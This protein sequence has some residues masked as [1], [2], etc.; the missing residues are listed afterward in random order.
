MFTDAPKHGIP[1]L[2]FKTNGV[3]SRTIH[4]SY[5]QKDVQTTPQIIARPTVT[6][7]LAL[8]AQKGMQQHNKSYPLLQVGFLQILNLNVLNCHAEKTRTGGFFSLLCNTLYAPNNSKEVI[9]ADY[10]EYLTPLTCTSI[11]P[12]LSLQR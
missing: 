9:A 6:K 2:Y 5:L 1:F 8:Q 11:F 12:T 7:L 10:L 4:Q 3:K